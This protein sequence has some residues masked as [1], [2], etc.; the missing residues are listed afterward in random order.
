M[1]SEDVL[2]DL[3]RLA[4][5]DVEVPENGLDRVRRALELHRE[6][7]ARRSRW[8]P[9]DWNWPE[10][11]QLAGIAA[12]LVLV[13]AIATG[14]AVV[15]HGS[16]G[17]KSASTAGV[18]IPDGG[19]ASSSAASAGSGALA[20]AVGPSEQSLANTGG[21][22]PGTAGVAGP[23]V[24]KTANISVQVAVGQVGATLDQLRGLA[25]TYGGFV[26]ASSG[27]LD[28]SDP[29][30]VATLRVPVASYTALRDAITKGTYGKV[31]SVQEAGQD[32]TSQYTDLAAR[33]DALQTQR[34]T[35]LTI[36]SRATTI[37][38]TLA[39][40]QQLDTLQQQLEQL[41]GQQKVLADQ[42]DLATVGV[43]I[44]QKGSAALAPAKSRTG[45]D[46]AAHE[47]WWGFS[48]GLQGLLAASGVLLLIVLIVG[49]LALV[50]RLGVRIVRR[51][52]I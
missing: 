43:T 35:Y 11:S 9:R 42:S 21:S 10:R 41:Q 32:V 4:G 8:S 20:P 2:G 48:D 52:L 51:R 33:I 38:D 49:V 30:G 12:A 7:P 14:I 40:Q 15:G 17:S 3:L 25:T 6:V 39:V 44:T 16:S 45:F 34:Q 36:L 13:A 18:A 31:T 28:S 24:V 29:N 23:R 22:S 5:E 1:I 26:A 37:Q 50:G 19:A 46:K 27:T 47:A